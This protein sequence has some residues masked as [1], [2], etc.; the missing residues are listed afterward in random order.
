MPNSRLGY[1]EYLE[2]RC[3]VRHSADSLPAPAFAPGCDLSAD[4]RLLPALQAALDGGISGH[5]GGIALAG[6]SPKPLAGFTLLPL[7]KTELRPGTPAENR[8]NIQGFVFFAL[9]QA[10]YADWVRSRLPAL[11]FDLRWLP[12]GTPLPERTLVQRP[13]VNTGPS[14]EWR[15]VASMRPAPAGAGPAQWWVLAGG[16]ALAV[17]L[18]YLLVTQARLRLL[19]ERA[20]A[21][22]AALNQT[23]ERRIVERTAELDVALR[24]ERELNRLKGNFVAMVSHE[25]RTP[26]AL[27]LGS[28]EILSAYLDRLPPEKRQRHLDTIQD[29][30]RRMALLV[31]D[32]LLF[33]RAEAGRL[34]FK[35]AAV[36]LAALADRVVEEVRS[37]TGDRCPVTAAL[38]APGPPVHVDAGLVRQ[39]LVNL[40]TNAVKFSAPGDPVSLEI[41]S[42]PGGLVCRVRDRGAGISEADLKRLFT[43]FVRGENAGRVPGTGL[44]LVIARRC[45]E[46][47]GG[48]LELTSRVGEGTLATLRLP[49]CVPGQTDVFLK[50][51]QPPQSPP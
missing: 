28:A 46:R 33:S 42:P 1:A 39:I 7:V 51:I 47:H 24:E 12:P 14:G 27:I 37:S 4:A 19:A 29:A 50:Q 38:P 21:Q 3:V 16:S 8:T 25:I 43:P 20:R 48:S 45:A 5:V 2:G 49:V 17:L 32:V 40:L 26:L 9:D 22:T 44:G 11:G 41:E 36:D 31:D 15:W 35:P 10:H 23:L 30:V 6:A 13:F 34:E 18:Y